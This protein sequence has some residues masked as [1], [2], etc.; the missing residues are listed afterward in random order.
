M[1]ILVPEKAFTSLGQCDDSYDAF[2][3]QRLWSRV[4]YISGAALAVTS[5]VLFWTSR[6]PSTEKSAHFTC[7][8]TLN[9]LSCR[10]LW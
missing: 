2:T 6:S 8:P 1:N 4:G 3:S 5:G 7:A 9:G 10:S